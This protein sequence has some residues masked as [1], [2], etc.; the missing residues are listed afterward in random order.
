M[1]PNASSSA[2]SKLERLAHSRA[3]FLPAPMPSSSSLWS[4]ALSAAGS[5][6]QQAL[7][8]PEGLASVVS[9]VDQHMKEARERRTVQAT[10]PPAPSDDV[11]LGIKLLRVADLA[12]AASTE[13]LA[14]SLRA[15]GLRL[16][17]FFPQEGARPQ[18]YLCR[19]PVPGSAAIKEAMFCV[20]R[21]TDSKADLLRDLM[22]MPTKHA[23]GV[24]FHHGFLSGVCS[25]GS[26]CQQLATH[27]G[28]EARGMPL[29]VVGHSLGGSLAITVVLSGLVPPTHHGPITVVAFGEH[30]PITWLAD[31]VALAWHALGGPPR[32]PCQW[33]RL[34]LRAQ[35]PEQHSGTRDRG[36]L[37]VYSC[38][39]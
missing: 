18:W 25:D 2:H 36:P 34:S 12:Y 39:L 11:R 33:R 13:A 3:L 28:H 5:L 9:Q 27:L 17:R 4:R 31:A 1:W 30:A 15:E 6:A 16:L 32:P 22:A 29:Y 21:G 10:L 14:D 24:H 26:V 37:Q 23:S 8:N 7:E 35:P 20:F 19:G 38:S